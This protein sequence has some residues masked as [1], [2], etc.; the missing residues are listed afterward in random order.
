VPGTGRASFSARTSSGGPNGSGPSLEE[1]RGLDQPLHLD[2]VC[3]HDIVD[4]EMNARHTLVNRYWNPKGN[5]LGI[6]VEGGELL[7]KDVEIRPLLEHTPPG[8][9]RAPEMSDKKS[10]KRPPFARPG[11]IP[12]SSNST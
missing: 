6:W 4:V 3:K 12:G 7:V 9:L 5:R 1:L 10:R 11:T 2:I 8:A